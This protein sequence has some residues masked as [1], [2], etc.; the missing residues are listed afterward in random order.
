MAEYG[1]DLAVCDGRSWSSR[2][3]CWQSLDIGW[4][5]LATSCQIGFCASLCKG[6]A[7]SAHEGERERDTR[8]AEVRD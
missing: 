7:Y 3:S 1:P 2:I 4:G 5:S 8:I 6:T